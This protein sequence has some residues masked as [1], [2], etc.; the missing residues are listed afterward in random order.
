[1]SGL[2]LK[3]EIQT[4]IE[5]YYKY[6]IAI[7]IA[8]FSADL[9]TMY[10]KPALLPQQSTPTISSQ[11][12]QASRGSQSYNSIINRNLFSLDGSIP[13]SLS[14][15]KSDKSFDSEAPAIPSNLPLVLN[16]TIVHANP[17][18]S[19]ASVLIRGKNQSFAFKVGD[20][21]EGMARVTKIQRKKLIFINIREGRKEFIEIPDDA[22]LTI[23]L[24]TPKKQSG[25]ASDVVRKSGKFEWEVTRD[26]LNKL[27]QD[28]PSL[29]K[30]ARVEPNFIPGGGV[31]GFRF[32]W[33]APDSI[34]N[35]LGFNV[36]DVIR[37]V[38]GEPIN[39]ARSAMEAYKAMQGN[40]SI[41]LDVTRNGVEETFVYDITQ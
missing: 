31:Q 8:Y 30:Q 19:V 12:L 10:M 16:G 4:K 25:S 37:G 9:G 11:P 32:T 39:D 17:E 26:D 18:K 7:L 41:R 23:G 15:K 2:K 22:K 1:M 29:L 40:D 14:E 28:L 38:D 20:N 27:T 6:F 36:G 3:N 13:E 5:G 33:I 21:I 34:F 35:K 24:S